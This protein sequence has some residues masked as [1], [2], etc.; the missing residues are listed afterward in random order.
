MRSGANLLSFR[1]CRHCGDPGFAPTGPRRYWSCSRSGSSPLLRVRGSSQA[2]QATDTGTYPRPENNLPGF[3]LHTSAGEL[4]PWSAAQCMAQSISVTGFRRQS[5]D[6]PGD[7]GIG[8]SA[9][10]PV[11]VR[12]VTAKSRHS[13]GRRSWQARRRPGPPFRPGRTN[14]QKSQA[15]TSSNEHSSAAFPGLVNQ[16]LSAAQGLFHRT[17]II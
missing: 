13:P 3:P 17:R 11:A 5:P 10:R 8:A 2:L 16:Q 14:H 1:H 15:R 9:T 4:P 6:L 12:R 7:A